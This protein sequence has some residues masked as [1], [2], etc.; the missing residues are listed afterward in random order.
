M[1][2]QNTVVSF[3]QNWKIS[4]G[5]NTSHNPSIWKWPIPYVPWI[6]DHFL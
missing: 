1:V 5:E 2:Q 6:S 4:S 3:E